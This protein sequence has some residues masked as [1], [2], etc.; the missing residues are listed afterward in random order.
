M[1]F[2]LTAEHEA[3][4]AQVRELCE[5]FG[6][7]YFLSLE[8]GHRYPEEFVRTMLD[9]GLLSVLIPKEYGGLGLG[10]TEATIVIE[11][12]AR[13]GANATACHA[14]IYNV[15]G[16]LRH[17]SEDLKRRYLPG[18]AS[19]DL[20]YLSFALT[21][22]E[23]GLNTTALKTTAVRDGDDYVINGRK[24]WIS[25]IGH[26]DLMLVLARTTPLEEVEKKTT[27]LTAF[28]VEL[29]AEGM[30]MER[31]DTMMN[32]ETYR[33]EFTNLR[34]P[35]ANIVGELDRGFRYVVSGING[36][37]ICA[38]AAAVGDARWSLE[39]AVAFAN[40]RIVFDRPIG[41]NQG[42]QFPIARAWAATEAASLMRY[43]AAASFDAGEDSGADANTAKLLAA[44]ASWDAVNAAMSTYGGYAFAKDHHIERKFREARLFINA[45]GSENLILAHIGQ[46]VLGMPRSF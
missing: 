35:A 43:K 34:V 10:V 18:I 11:E 30:E 17:G 36:D 2:K 3:L 32:L 33:V 44:Q 9:S 39:R 23:A 41:Q 42:I 45:P 37:R 21:E 4:R 19:G 25:R 24:N 40:E 13:A 38:A 15:L 6:D 16:L 46:H 5:P 29:P 7:D 12:I 27:G 31:V 20:R 28:L 22:H 26:S 14:Q 1:D 8:D